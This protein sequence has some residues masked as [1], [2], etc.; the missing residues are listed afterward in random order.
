MPSTWSNASEGSQK[1]PIPKVAERAA[2][3]FVCLIIA[4]LDTTNFVFVVVEEKDETPSQLLS[5]AL[6]L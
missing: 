2:E 1:Q 5:K 4:L 3:S 6:T